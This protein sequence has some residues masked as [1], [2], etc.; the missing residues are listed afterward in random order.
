LDQIRLPGMP[1]FGILRGG[2]SVAARVLST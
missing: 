2:V 1:G